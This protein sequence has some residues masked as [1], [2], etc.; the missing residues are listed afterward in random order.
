MCDK[1]VRAIRDCEEKKSYETE[2]RRR[3]IVLRGGGRNE[4]PNKFA[5][6][7]ERERERESI[8][9]SEVRYGVRPLSA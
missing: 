7:R 6:R 2:R 4:R 8:A 1:V 5:L 3:R 9:F